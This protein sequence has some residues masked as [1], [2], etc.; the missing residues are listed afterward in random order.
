M[1]LHKSVVEK[2]LYLYQ[3]YGGFQ[4]DQKLRAMI[5]A[6]DLTPYE[7]KTTANQELILVLTEDYVKQLSKK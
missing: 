7:R 1:R 4:N 2:L 3:N 5:E 6:M